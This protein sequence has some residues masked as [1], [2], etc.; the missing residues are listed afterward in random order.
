V[1][2]DGAAR[3]RREEARPAVLRLRDLLKLE[4]FFSR[5]RRRVATIAELSGDTR[6]AAG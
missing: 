5:W 1:A 2:T 4:F 3:D 6:E